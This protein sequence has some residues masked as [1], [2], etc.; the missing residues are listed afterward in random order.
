MLVWCACWIY[1]WCGEWVADYGYVLYGKQGR[2][3]IDC[4]TLL[5]VVSVVCLCLGALLG[6]VGFMYGISK[7]E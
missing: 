4:Q 3:I 6:I 5:I 7:G 2:L 1:P